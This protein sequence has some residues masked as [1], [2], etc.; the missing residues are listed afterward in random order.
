MF[1]IDVVISGAERLDANAKTLLK[2]VFGCTVVSRYANNENGFLAQQPNDG[3]HFILNTAHYYFETLRLDADEPADDGEPARL[4]LTDFYNYAMPLIRYDT[5]DIVI[6]GMPQE[7]GKYSGK[8]VLTEISGRKADIIYDTRGKK[9]SPHFVALKFRP[10]DRLPRFQFIQESLKDFTLKLE[11][12]RGLY[13]DNDFHDTIRQLVGRDAVVKI[14]HVD[15]IQHH[16]SGK[17]RTI[18]CN[19]QPDPGDDRT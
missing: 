9:I 7:Q 15:K 11:G 8:K 18:I 13:D 1:S 17:F 5:E 19:Y 10:Y 2:K 3:D 12:V 6:A 14:D 16:S 4:V